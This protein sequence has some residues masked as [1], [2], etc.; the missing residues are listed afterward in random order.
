[1][2]NKAGREQLRALAGLHVALGLCQILKVP[3]HLT[4]QILK[5]QLDMLPGS[6]VWCI[7]FNGNY[8]ANLITMITQLYKIGTI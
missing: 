2:L 6:H 7:H 4:L 8:E 3:S 5:G 1:M